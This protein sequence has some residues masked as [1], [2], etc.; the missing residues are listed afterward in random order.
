MAVRDVYLD[1]VLRERWDDGTKVVTFYNAQG[2]QTSQRPYTAAENLAID[3][4][5]AVEALRVEGERIG[6]AQRAL[7]EASLALAPAPTVGGAWVQPTGATNAYAKDSVVTHAGKTW[8]SLTPF[9]VW[10]PGVSGWREQ[11][12]TGYPAW[13]QPTGT[14][15]AYP[16][17]AKVSHNGQNWEN[18][19]SAANVWEPGVFGWVVIP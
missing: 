7:V 3:Q 4:A 5:A 8:I 10:A 15:D 17:N 2:T 9:N 11:V 16:L 19:G 6:A 14:Q 18:T 1:N 13:I 12:A